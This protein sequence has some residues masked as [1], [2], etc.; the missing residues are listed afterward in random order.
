M[1]HKGCTQ[2][3]IWLNGHW[4]C[5]NNEC[6]YAQTPLGGREL[7][8]RVATVPR[9]QQYMKLAATT[10]RYDSRRLDAQEVSSPATS[11]T[12]CYRDRKLSLGRGGTTG[13]TEIRPANTNIRRI[14][15]QYSN[16]NRKPQSFSTPT[17]NRGPPEIRTKIRGDPRPWLT[18][19]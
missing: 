9:C 4:T 1:L 19:K 8:P 13:T 10:T 6:N 18:P 7:S 11:V 17:S 12:R 2:I 14:Y 3:V 5:I 16:F 15:L